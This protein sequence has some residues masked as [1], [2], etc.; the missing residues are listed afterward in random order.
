MSQQHKVEQQVQQRSLLPT[1]SLSSPLETVGTTSGGA[2]GGGKARLHQKQQRRQELPRCSFLSLVKLLLALALVG[3]S[4]FNVVFLA[5][6]HSTTPMHGRTPHDAKKE[7]LRHSASE[8]NRQRQQLKERRQGRGIQKEQQPGAGVSDV[9][10]FWEYLSTNL[11]QGWNRCNDNDNNTVLRHSNDSAAD[12][13][14]LRRTTATDDGAT[15]W[16]T[17]DSN[18]SNASFGLLAALQ[19]FRRGG[20]IGDTCQLPR[21]SASACNI[22]TYAILAV[23][24]KPSSPSPVNTMATIDL[25]SVLVDCMKWLLDPDASE[26]WLVLPL[27][28]RTALEADRPY[29][30]RLLAW[31]EQPQH[32]VHLAFAESIWD[33]VAQVHAASEETAIV[34]WRITEGSWRGNFRNDVR[35]G[36]RLWR[37]R[38]SG[39]YSSRAWS[40]AFVDNEKA[41]INEIQ[42]DRTVYCGTEP[43]RS[44]REVLPGN[45]SSEP[46]QPNSHMMVA[47]VSH[48]ILIH[49]RDYLCLLS[50]PVLAELRNITRDDSFDRVWAI[51]ARSAIALSLSL[52]APVPIK[53]Y[54]AHITHSYNWKE[55]LLHLEGD[56]PGKTGDIGWAHPLKRMLPFFGGVSTSR[57]LLGLPPP[58][59]CEGS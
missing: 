15:N 53:L 33:G 22:T 51:G 32:P 35:T 36:M 17:S 25:R 20:H 30:R 10:D 38:V 42:K 2:Q 26:I 55:S 13:S 41:G 43:I 58:A 57:F 31:D 46:E 47:D 6:H 11:A 1:S 8:N 48:G 18:S 34:W 28:A 21:L 54:D 27:N 3:L 7:L 49:H 4:L 23:V 50:H 37:R 9:A 56:Q 24:G 44:I 5:G 12:R 16:A 19:G 52:F 59:A 45:A 40:I 29:G 14:S 39:I